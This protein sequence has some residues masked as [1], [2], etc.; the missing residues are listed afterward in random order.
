MA[1]K[2][3]IDLGGNLYEQLNNY[4]R[5]INKTSQDVSELNKKV[6]QLFTGSAK[7]KPSEF[8]S[9]KDISQTKDVLKAIE[10]ERKAAS[11][12]KT[13]EL[14]SSKNLA[15]IQNVLASV[16]TVLSAAKGTKLFP[17]LKD[18]INQVDISLKKISSIKGLQYTKNVATEIA[19]PIKIEQGV[20]KG[21]SF[22]N[23]KNNTNELRAQVEDLAEQLS[24]A[25]NNTIL[26]SNYGKL[27]KQA[28]QLVSSLKL[29]SKQQE[30]LEGLYSNNVI[31]FPKANA[32]NAKKDKVR[33][34]SSSI[35]NPR[36]DK[37]F[38]AFDKAGLVASVAGIKLQ[39]NVKKLFEKINDTIV[40]KFALIQ[41]SGGGKL[42]DVLKNEASYFKYSGE[43]L[44]DRG[45]GIVSNIKDR[46]TKWGKIKDTN[47]LTNEELNKL[48]KK[49]LAKG[50]TKRKGVTESTIDEIFSKK[51]IENAAKARET[52]NKN[53]SSIPASVLQSE[54]FDEYFDSIFDPYKKMRE[55][56]EASY[57]KHKEEFERAKEEYKRANC[58]DFTKEKFEDFKEKQGQK[59]SNKGKTR[60]RKSSFSFKDD[61]EYKEY[62]KQKLQNDTTRAN[63]YAKTAS[64]A[65]RNISYKERNEAL[66]NKNKQSAI[67]KRYT[68]IAYRFTNDFNKGG[69]IGDGFWKTLLS[70]LTTQWRK[71]QF[72]TRG[73]NDMILNSYKQKKI[74]SIFKENALDTDAYAQTETFKNKRA[75]L[76][77]KF[78]V[79]ANLPDKD[80]IAAVG[81]KR[82]GKRALLKGLSIKEKGQV[83]GEMSQIPQVAKLLGGVGKILGPWMGVGAIIG[84]IA[85]EMGKLGAAAVKA[86]EGVQQLQT[87]LAVVFD[88]DIQANSMFRDIEAYAKK[89]PFGVETMTSQAILLKQSGVYA[90]DLMDTMQR[91]G[92]MS[93]GNAEKMKSISDVYARVI[94]S[95]TV[96]ARDMRQLS[97][98]GIASYKALSEATGIDRSLLRSKMQAGQITSKDFETMVKNLTDEGG[99]FYG[100]TERGAKTIAARRQNLSDAKEMAV[101][102]IGKI[103]ARA[104]G[105]STTDSLLGQG[106]SFLEGIFSKVENI[107]SKINDDKDMK[108]A[109]KKLEQYNELKQRR[110][111]ATTEEEKKFYQK[112]MDLLGAEIP[113]L[114]E[115]ELAAHARAYKA[116]QETLAGR[117]VISDEEYEA[118]VLNGLYAGV[119]YEAIDAMYISQYDYNKAQIKMKEHLEGYLQSEYAAME[120]R[121]YAAINKAIEDVTGGQSRINKAR[122]YYEKTSSVDKVRQGDEQAKKDAELRALYDYWDKKSIN[123]ETGQYELGRL[124]IK[125][126]SEAMKYMPAYG[127]KLELTKTSLLDCSK[128][129]VFREEK[130]GDLD[131]LKQNLQDIL[132]ATKNAN[133]DVY[134]REVTTQM[135]ALIDLLG[136]DF[137][138]NS[139][140][141]IDKLAQML[142]ID[143]PQAIDIALEA[144]K[145]AYKNLPAYASDS[146]KAQ[147]LDA[148][149][150]VQAI[151]D[152]VDSATQSKMIDTN[153]KTYLN[154][155]LQAPLW[156]Q[157]ISKTTGISA[158]RLANGGASRAMGDYTRNFAQREMFTSL[159]KSLM[160]N[161]V[162]LRE[163]SAILQKRAQ[164]VDSYDHYNFDW[165]K[166]TGDLE[167]LAAGRSIA[168]QQA[169]INMYQSQIDTLSDLEMAGVATRD[170]WT[171]LEDIAAQLGSGFNLSAERMADGSYRFTE[172]TIRAAEE[173]KQALSA[174]K[175]EQQISSI[176]KSELNSL[177]LDTLRSKIVSAVYRGDIEGAANYNVQGK[178]KYADVLNK[179]ILEFTGTGAETIRTLIKDNN[180]TNE[181]LEKLGKLTGNTYT[182]AKTERNLR[183]ERLSAADLK[184]RQAA[185]LAER[186]Y[187][188]DKRAALDAANEARRSAEKY[189]SN[190]RGSKIDEDKVFKDAFN[191]NIAQQ[192]ADAISNNTEGAQKAFEEAK[193]LYKAEGYKFSVANPNGIKETY[194]VNTRNMTK[195]GRVLTEEEFMRDIL[196]IFRRVENGELQGSEIQDFLD[197][198]ETVIPGLLEKIKD[199]NE[200]L[201]ENTTALN[202]ENAQKEMA[203]TIENLANIYAATGRLGIKAK[204]KTEEGAFADMPFI[205]K[206]RGN[207][208]TFGQERLL[209]Q[210]GFDSDVNYNAVM[211][212]VGAAMSP[213]NNEKWNEQEKVKL[214]EWSEREKSV[215]ETKNQKILEKIESL[216][217]GFLK[218]FGR[219]SM[220]IQKLE[221]GGWD[222]N[223]NIVGKNA[224]EVN[225]RVISAKYAQG[226]Q[227][228]GENGELRNATLDDVK[229]AEN[230]LRDI[231]NEIDLLRNENE[232]L[233]N[234]NP[235]LSVQYGTLTN[236]ASLAA[237]QEN[238]AIREERMQQAENNSSYYEQIGSYLGSLNLGFA[239]KD[240][241]GMNRFAAQ[242]KIDEYNLRNGTDYSLT[243]N[244]ENSLSSMMNSMITT[245]GIDIAK[246]EE[247]RDLLQE[248]GFDIDKMNESWA[249]N[250]AGIASA[251]EVTHELGQELKGAVKSFA[252]NAI[253]STTKQLGANFYKMENSLMTQEEASDAIKKTLASTGAELL[254]NIGS[255]AVNAGLALIEGGARMGYAG[256]PYIAAGIGLAAAGGFA[257]IGAGALDAY[258]NNDDKDKTEDELNKLNALKDNLADLLEQA[259]N[260]AIYYEK[261]LRHRTAIATNEAISSD[262]ISVTKTNDMILSPS[263]A[264]STAPDDYIM[265]MKDPASL[266]QNNGGSSTVNFQIINNSGVPLNVE[267]SSKEDNEDG[268]QDVIV[269]LN[270]YIKDQITNGEYDDAFDAM[271][272]RRAGYSV[273]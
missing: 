158:D 146:L 218:N 226:E 201:E 256:I 96:T 163:L 82:G 157:I 251:K 161:G 83:M 113:E 24:V 78:R 134:A 252:S 266:M 147:K 35:D 258:A 34:F 26:Q 222:E 200:A 20:R 191:A 156:M 27:K 176:I 99:T 249:A 122:D 182:G 162:S 75:K 235:Y 111:D 89:S 171:N 224:A 5:A 42:K 85:I 23:A 169:L 60:Q 248:M 152:T 63:A 67:D 36:N 228:V 17:D 244:G 103:V 209:K 50:G 41:T 206:M 144:A 183:V 129:G 3:E 65:E 165:Q 198:A 33:Q 272:M 217:D 188:I 149:K 43:I 16:T 194:S 106:I 143:L 117:Q 115:N 219:N 71:G 119:S 150:T 225:Y 173:M 112:Q 179:T 32:H 101:A 264:F 133:G 192:V 213:Q 208:N 38:S 56:A 116:I 190:N 233:Q 246:V 262:T 28:P 109:K 166:A 108:S 107:A 127:E 207:F 44:K 181:A 223:G 193:E 1:K 168:T 230:I 102:E 73:L 31:K 254:S 211:K 53:L 14:I 15:E 155:R 64:V 79:D 37:S 187:G 221:K 135:Q 54:D 267:S 9:I 253:L 268:G 69:V 7:T 240:V 84:K 199:V 239:S 92:D 148:I 94:S 30:A 120:E 145:T 167:E 177:N 21:K 214:K 202:N 123:K 91:I 255:A 184:E 154:K 238:A 80:F 220:Q 12:K 25:A 131:Q 139:G 215:E 159:G 170:T 227:I 124:D 237:R 245:D 118:K 61:D 126:L 269:T 51:N 141:K 10:N 68:D 95:T 72:N 114:K 2:I 76:A 242:N 212:R 81:E 13:P 52:K 100:A 160:Q 48:Y 197:F 204:E 236:E 174:K 231:K 49:K 273:S 232:A 22:V 180:L 265:A 86:Y 189:N 260:D 259:K 164:G 105:T 88:T 138:K 172:A 178:E 203:T 136:T 58:D 270:S 77:K 4:S 98:A 121:G 271:K 55:E 142:S 151:K 210:M 247:F 110:D 137:A 132:S 185:I 40:S 70:Q 130:Q 234:V 196:E 243:G 29:M 104:G 39:D 8:F 140:Q 97:N 186:N 261:N 90:S 45:I 93:S 6:N 263:G 62:L 257:A 66:D 241:L 87:Q 229:N 125:E 153:N 250:A 18:T 57:K 19:N 128:G 11:S 46:F 216:E 175:F 47:G 74:T 205:S 195:N 59:K